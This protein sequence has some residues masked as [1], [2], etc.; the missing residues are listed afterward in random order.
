MRLLYLHGF[1]SSPDS[2]K[3]VAFERYLT[4]KGFE[5]ERL[6][7]RLPQREKLRVSAM[8]AATLEAIGDDRRVVLVGSSLGGLVA[9]HVASRHAAVVALVLMAPAFGFA[10]RW[11]ESLGP[12]RLAAWRDGER[13]EVE[14]HAGG[15]PLGIDYGFYEDARKVDHGFPPLPAAT[16][17]FHGRHDDVVPLEGSRRLAVAQPAVRLVELDDDHALTESIDAICEQSYVFLDS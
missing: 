14:D 17:V 12:E 3:G 16:L 9:A 15:A 5:V 10:A 7:M 1:A 8:I 2:R 13:L 11:A 4:P 6:D